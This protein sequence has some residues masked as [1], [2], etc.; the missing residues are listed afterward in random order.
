[1]DNFVIVWTI[2][3]SNFTFFDFKFVDFG[4]M[5]TNE[6]FNFWFAKTFMSRRSIRYL[7]C[8]FSILRISKFRYTSLF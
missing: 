7:L 8:Q 6:I 4:E 5:I 3:L 2:T 1:M